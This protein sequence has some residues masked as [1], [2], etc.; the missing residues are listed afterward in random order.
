METGDPATSAFLLLPLDKKSMMI[1]YIVSVC[2]F[3]WTNF[4]IVLSGK[5]YC[6]IYNS[7]DTSSVCMELPHSYIRVA[8]EV[9][10]DTISQDKVKLTVGYGPE[11]N[12]MQDLNLDIYD[13]FMSYL[14]SLVRI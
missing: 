10:E 11:I 6:Y 14:I 12:H 8:E 1:V 5:R 2:I 9:M 3:Q 7:I 13:H 4:L